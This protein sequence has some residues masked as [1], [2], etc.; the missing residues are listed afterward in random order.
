MSVQQRHYRIALSLLVLDLSRIK[1]S[2]GFEPNALNLLNL[3]R[4][5]STTSST[6]ATGSKKQVFWGVLEWILWWP[7]HPKIGHNLELLPLRGIAHQ[8]LNAARLFRA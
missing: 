2:A 6:S 5:T 4:C 1:M 7:Q 8:L 3:A